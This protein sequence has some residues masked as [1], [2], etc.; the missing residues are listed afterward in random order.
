M[1]KERV[2]DFDPM[3]ITKQLEDFLQSVNKQ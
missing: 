3:I 1:G 2:K